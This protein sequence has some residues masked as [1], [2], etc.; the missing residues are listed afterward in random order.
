M[1]LLQYYLKDDGVFPNSELP[2]LLYKRAL[3]I[4]LFFA[5]L[6]VKKLL[7]KHHYTNNWRNGIYTY[8]H[9]HSNTHEVMAVIKGHTTLLLGGDKGRKVK[10]EK[11]DVI[12]IPAG[13][14]HKNLGKEKDVICIGG[15]PQGRDYNMNYGKK[16]ERP[17]ADEK[18]AKVK[19]PRYDPVTGQRDPMNTIWKKKRIQKSTSN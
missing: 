6:Q 4:P 9:Y 13:V 15:Y 5:A 7:Q 10:I 17:D 19:I 12:L 18:I 16:E 1:K 3:K 8:H 14:A 11:G 2:V